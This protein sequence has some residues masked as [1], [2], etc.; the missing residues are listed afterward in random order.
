M[1]LERY[2]RQ[3]VLPDF[4]LE[5]QKKLKRS[6]VLV[7]GA[8]GLGV[9]VLQYL[10]GM[11]VGTITILDGDEVS[12]SNLHRQVIYT[13]DDIGKKK[14]KVA[15]ERLQRLNPEIEVMAISEMLSTSNGKDFIRNCDVVVDCTDNLE[16]RYILN[17]FC[18]FLDKPFVYG[19]LYRHEGH[20][21]VFNFNGSVSY[22]DVYPDDS[23]KVNNC[24]EIGVLGVLPGII[25]SYQAMET[26]KVLTGFGETLAGKL[27]V[28]DATNAEHNVFNLGA[29][30][31][32][33]IEVK[34]IVEAEERT[35]ITWEDVDQMS[36][37]KMHFLDIRPLSDF[38]SSHDDRFEN[39]PIQML[40]GF[41]PEPEYSVVLVCD[42]GK[43][44]RQA[45]AILAATYP[46][47]NLY[48]IE[49]GYQSRRNE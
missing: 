17:D 6:K 37:G 12:L 19:A 46:S 45:A 42:Q 40:A 16:S 23:V 31:R 21:S 20:L 39:I 35:S 15:K 22:R 25:G 7:V 27:L 26:I 4:G 2:Q 33:N 43:T 28:V 3:I 49:G 5:G 30:K 11:G 32:E 9:P 47:L 18:V 36:S 48:Q 8:G 1:N 29:G 10:A 24:N 13:S 14:A 38:E 34:K 41:V 44:T